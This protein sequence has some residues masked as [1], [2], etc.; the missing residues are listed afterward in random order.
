MPKAKEPWSIR[1]LKRFSRYTYRSL[2]NAEKKHFKRIARRADEGLLKQLKNE[3]QKHNRAR[4]QYSRTATSTKLHGRI[5]ANIISDVA[6]KSVGAKEEIS[7]KDFGQVVR[8]T[9]KYSRTLMAEGEMQA[10]KAL[11]EIES[12]CGFP[13]RKKIEKEVNNAYRILQGALPPES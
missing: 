7:A 13:L 2:E 10:T 9:R 3:L 4:E 12:L 11:A 1:N 6:L 5:I 8:A